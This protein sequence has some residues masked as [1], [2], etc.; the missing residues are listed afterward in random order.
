MLQWTLAFKFSCGR[1][2]LIFLLL[3]NYSCPHFSITL[4]CPTHPHL[5]HSIFPP[6]SLSME[7]LHMFLDLTLPLLSP[8]IS[9]T[10]P[11]WSLLVY[12]LFPCLWFCFAC[13][14]LLLIRFQLQVRSYGIYLSPTGLFQL[15]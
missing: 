8:I 9:L 7:P 14:F 6:L 10:P 4:P 2:F 13:L 12:S 11:F 3:F 5:P 15:A 1:I